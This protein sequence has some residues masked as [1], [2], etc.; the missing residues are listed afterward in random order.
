MSVAV[1]RDEGQPQGL[2]IVVWKLQSVLAHVLWQL[3]FWIVRV[4]VGQLRGLWPSVRLARPTRVRRVSFIVG[5]LLTT[6]R[7]DCGAWLCRP[8]CLEVQDKFSRTFDRAGWS[9][10][11]LHRRPHSVCHLPL[12]VSSGTGS[13]GGIC[14]R[15]GKITVT[16]AP[17]G[18]LFR[19]RHYDGSP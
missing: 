3:R 2:R 13:P 15:I 8:L 4:A 14:F 7:F 1:G 5:L 19:G 9:L 16:V 11:I 10:D 18:S 6:L 12:Q 17:F